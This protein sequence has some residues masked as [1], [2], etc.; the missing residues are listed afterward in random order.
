MNILY[1][2][3]FFLLKYDEELSIFENLWSESN[4][5]TEDDY[6]NELL[7]YA[8]LAVKHKPRNYLVNSPD[9]AFTA[10]PELQLWTVEN[11]FPKTMHA[12]AKKM[13]II[14]ASDIF[15]QVSIEQT[16]EE[17][18]ELTNQVITRYFDDYQ[19]A[20]AWLAE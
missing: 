13:A 7:N 10:T 11:V 12:E 16:V 5:L 18:A 1:Q 9:F 19:A 3:K 14:V 4:L 17:G 20:M 6:K 2:S 15:A 8:N